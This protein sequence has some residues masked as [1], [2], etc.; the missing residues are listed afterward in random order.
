MRRGSVLVRTGQTIARGA[1]LGNVGF[2]GRADFAHVHLSVRHNGNV[3]DPFTGDRLNSACRSS[4]TTDRALWSDR[5]LDLLPYQRSQIMMV[6]FAGEALQHRSLVRDHRIARPDRDSKA[7]V[8][9]A[10]IINLRKGDRIKVG[11]SGPDGFA[12]DHMTKP[13]QRNK[14]DF[15]VFA[16]KKLRTARWAPGAYRGTI[17][18]LRNGKIFASKDAMTAL[19]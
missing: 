4:E 11:A 10:R 16:G 14:A 9:F 8:V 6:G 7:I 2:S 1:H 5:V 19:D 12:V 3:I 15:T 18:I 17:K 13:L